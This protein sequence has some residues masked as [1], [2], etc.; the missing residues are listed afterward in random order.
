[1]AYDIGP[2]IGIKGEKEFNNSIK[3][4]NN[5]LKEC[6]SEMNAL[7]AKFAGNEKI[8]LFFLLHFEPLMQVPLIL[9]FVL[10]VPSHKVSLSSFEHHTVSA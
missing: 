8:F 9:Q 5:S 4:I 10:Q 7:T 2:R 6:G 3:S 1:M